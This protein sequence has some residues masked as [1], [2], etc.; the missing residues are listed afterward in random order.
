V[1]DRFHL[2][3]AGPLAHV[4]FPGIARH[5]LDNGLGVW[6]IVQPAVPVV[7]LVLVL[8]T[9]TARDPA[10]RPGLTG[11][12]ADLLDEG[13]GSRDAIELSDALARIGSHLDVDTA[14]DAT[15]IGLT[16]LARF[17]P[18]AMELLADVVTRPH[19]AEADL[20]RVRELRINR[21]RQMR[22]LPG[23][24]GDRALLAAIFG[25]H[26]YGHGAFGTTRALEAITVDEARVFWA[27]AFGPRR[28]TLVVAGDVGGAAAVDAARAAFGHWTGGQAR[29]TIPP[30]ASPPVAG[31]VLIVNRP[32]SPQS[33]LR[34]GHGGPPRRTPA[35][36]PLV[37][38]NA[39]LGGQFT[40]RINRKLR[41]AM[42]VTYGAR[43]SFDFRVAGGSFACDAS[44]DLA[45]TTSAIVEILKECQ[46][47]RAA[48]AVGAEE[49]TRAKASLTRGYVKHFETAGQ[50]ARAAAQ[51]A[52]FELDEDE[53]DRFVPRIEAVAEADVAATAREF[54]HPGD[55]AIVVVGDADRCAKE[56]ETLNRPIDVFEPEF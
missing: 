41:E 8:D 6:S 50:L 49:L 53:F 48:D 13:A 29:A 2:P 31:R 9:G 32:G 4:R 19:L 33:D 15:T 21:L 18:Q 7:S 24:A 39:I 43:S 30:P 46:M 17:L 36:H 3:G 55:A 12:V 16:T 35:Y 37:T 42:G 5:T 40:S 27:G 14:P 47:I 25:P 20:T 34:V 10:D 56:L 22:R 44:V 23:A 1:N 11:L 45:A 54:L 26:P 28:T 38:L 52:S 51:I